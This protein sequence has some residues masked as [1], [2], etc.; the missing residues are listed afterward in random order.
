MRSELKLNIYSFNAVAAHVLGERFPEFSHSTVTRWYN[1]ESAAV[2]ARALRYWLKRSCANLDL[3]DKMDLV[4]RTGELA[5]LFG[6]DFFSV[7][8]RGS[9]FRVEAVMLRALKPLNYV[10]VSP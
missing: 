3:I 8:S 6:V 5:R 4:G 7:L 2:R 9:Q 1:N 10:V